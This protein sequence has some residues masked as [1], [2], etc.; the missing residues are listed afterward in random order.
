MTLVITDD[1]G[2]TDR[3]QRTLTVTTGVP[4]ASFSSPAAT[5]VGRA[6]RF[7]ASGSSDPNGT[8][9]G[10]RWNFGD[11][12]TQSTAAPLTSHTYRA[13]GTMTVTLTITDADGGGAGAQ[14]TV[15]VLPLGCVVP[16][17]LGRTVGRASRALH[18]AGCR[19][20]PVKRQH[21]GPRRATPA[22]AGDPTVD[23]DRRGQTGW[24]A[25]RGHRRQIALVVNQERKARR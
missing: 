10:Y 19:L 23:P 15:K 14:R 3:A 1:S 8:I 24:H 11:G 7:D 12:Q 5:I 16:R 25:S 9:T 6:I 21:A 18:A 4:S 22:R 13:S 20:G 2:S 17:L